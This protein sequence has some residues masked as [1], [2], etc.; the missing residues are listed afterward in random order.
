MRIA[1]LVGLWNQFFFSKVSPYPVAAFRIVQGIMVLQFA[2]SLAPDL[3][4]W[5]G[6][7]GIVT[8]KTLSWDAVNK[9]NLLAYYPQSNEWLL[10]LWILLIVAALCLTIGFQTR[11]SS[12]IVFLLVITFCNRN[13]FLFNAG[14]TFLRTMCCWLVMAPSNEVWSV[15]SYLKNRNSERN[16]CPL[17]SA[18]AWRA[19]QIQMCLVYF[20][21]FSAKTPG[22]YWA[23]GEAVYI[24]SRFESLQRLPMPFAFDDPVM[25]AIFTWG[26]LAV[27]FA[28][29]TLVWIKDIRYLVLACG[30]CLHLTIDWC[31][32]I[33]MFEFL[34]IVSF[35]LWIDS[36]H[37]INAVEY[38]K[39]LI[40]STF[41][42]IMGAPSPA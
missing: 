19:L 40:R 20:S 32:S 2:V 41:G 11:I 22:W 27:E 7:P 28:L 18:W 3:Y 5:F 34:M 21:A 12:I 14:D 4:V 13:G 29:F 17:I 35:V 39:C 9:F 6:S 24:A 16:Y 33:P 31:M 23:S 38:G 15:D 25:S 30:V 10:A 26:T 36:N 37:L 42:R 1:T 8:Q